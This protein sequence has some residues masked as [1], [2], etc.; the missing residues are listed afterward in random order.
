VVCGIRCG[1]VYSVLSFV[2]W[3]DMLWCDLVCCVV[4]YGMVCVILCC[5]VL[6]YIYLLSMLDYFA[7]I[8]HDVI[9]TLVKFAWECS[10]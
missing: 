5:G 1:V 7:V 3:C 4:W 2:L 8:L 10:D 6:L 9:F